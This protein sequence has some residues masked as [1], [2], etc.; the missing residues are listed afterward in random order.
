MLMVARL[1]MIMAHLLWLDAAEGVHLW[2]RIQRVHL[3]E[4]V[5]DH[6]PPN[7][8]TRQR[9]ELPQRDDNGDTNGHHA[10]P[11]LHHLAIVEGHNQLLPHGSELVEAIE[12]GGDDVRS[13]THDLRG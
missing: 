8:W 1:H 10:Q 13:A 3:T 12:G 9:L 11:L 7:L 4:S 5:L 2:D 6:L